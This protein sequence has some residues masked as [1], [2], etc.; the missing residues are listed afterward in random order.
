MVVVE[1]A[2]YLQKREG[3]TKREGGVRKKKK[4]KCKWDDKIPTERIYLVHFINV[5]VRMPTYTHKY[6]NMCSLFM[7]LSSVS[8]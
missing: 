8:T 3:N 5:W 2:Y 4:N 1:E 7:Q 6:P